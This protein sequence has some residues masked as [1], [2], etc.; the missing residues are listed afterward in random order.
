MVGEND[1]HSRKKNVLYMKT[2]NKTKEEH[3]GGY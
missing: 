1:S 3:H 2:F